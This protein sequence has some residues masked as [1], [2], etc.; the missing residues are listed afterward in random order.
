[1]IKV[2]VLCFNFISVMILKDINLSR[3]FNTLITFSIEYFYT[4]KLNMLYLFPQFEQG[5]GQLRYSAVCGMPIL[6]FRLERI[7][8]SQ[9][10]NT[11]SWIFR[12]KGG[13]NNVRYVRP[14]F[15]RTFNLNCDVYELLFQNTINL[16]R[17]CFVPRNT[18]FYWLAQKLTSDF[19]FKKVIAIFSESRQ[20]S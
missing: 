18:C 2:S 7:T 8:H 10:P 14:V 5:N 17:S 9:F 4:A 15:Q 12:R 11:S 20:L 13:F 3:Y 16:F 6:I 19:D 1:M